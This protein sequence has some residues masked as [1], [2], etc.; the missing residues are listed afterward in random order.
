M[1]TPVVILHGYNDNRSSFQPLAQ[2]LK[3]RG[4]TVVP[5]YLGDYITLEKTITIPDLAKAFEA[6]LH[7]PRRSGMRARPRSAALR[8][9]GS[10]FAGYA[11]RAMRM[12]DGGLGVLQGL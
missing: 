6:A 7:L 12:V 1:P 5:I 9:M 4:F 2:F 10:K 3:S 8:G 11:R